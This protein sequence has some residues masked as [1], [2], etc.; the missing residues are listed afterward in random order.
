MSEL[1]DI[2]ELL[3]THRKESNDWRE[4]VSTSLTEIKIHNEYTQKKLEIVDKLEKQSQRQKG[5]LYAL[6]LIGLGG[7]E[8]FF[9]NLFIK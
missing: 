8:E 5:F 2:K 4:K 3:E 7:I 6:S 9:R 1:Q